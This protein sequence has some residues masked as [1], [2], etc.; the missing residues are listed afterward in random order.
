MVTTTL[1]V[2]FMLFIAFYVY[3]Y[4]LLLDDNEVVRVFSRIIVE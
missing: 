2:L 4:A 1:S 3:L